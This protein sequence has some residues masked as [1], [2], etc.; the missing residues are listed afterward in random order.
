MMSMY[1]VHEDGSNAEDRVGFRVR[2]YILDGVADLLQS[3]KVQVNLTVRRFHFLTD[4]KQLHIVH[5]LFYD[6][7]CFFSPTFLI[8]ESFTLKGQKV[9]KYMSNLQLNLIEICLYNHIF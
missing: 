4:A 3:D 6:T 9:K 5:N 1:G 8:Q 7:F 2:W